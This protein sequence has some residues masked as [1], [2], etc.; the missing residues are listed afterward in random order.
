MN[1]TI[2]KSERLDI[3]QIYNMVKQLAIYE[4]EPDAVTATIDDYYNDWD[5]DIYQVLVAEKEDKLIGIAIYYMT[6]STWKGKMLY[7]EDF[8]IDEP[9]RRTGIGQQLF[10]AFMKEAKDLGTK[11]VKWQV[12]DWNEPAIRFYEKN[13]AIFEDE[14]KNCKIFFK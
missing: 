1:I 5:A 9:F 6:Y 3:P 7:L 12:L 13:K 4:N 10:N 14:W 11:L 2:R 8:I